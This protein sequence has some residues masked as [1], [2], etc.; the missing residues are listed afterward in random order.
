M[1]SL[2]ET[3][4]IEIVKLIDQNLNGVELEKA[5]DLVRIV[6]DYVRKSRKIIIS[7]YD[8]NKE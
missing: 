4:S 7:K 5:E 8:R 1:Y 6:C 3:C 2:L